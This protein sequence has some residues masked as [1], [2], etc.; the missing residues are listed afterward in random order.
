MKICKVA[1]CNNK[2]VIEG[3]CQRHY[4]HI[5]RYG[6]I[7]KRTIKDPNEIILCGNYAEVVIYNV[8]RNE[9]A[10][11]LIS[12]KDVE[13]TAKHKWCV[14]SGYATSCI[15]GKMCGMNRFIM[16]EELIKIKEK[17]DVDHINGNKLDN[18]RSNLRLATRSQNLM[19]KKH[20]LG[21]YFNKQCNK[22]TAQ[23]KANNK[24][25]NLGAYQNK[26]EALKVRRQ[27]EL[28]YFKE[29]AK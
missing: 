24:C 9:V 26:E 28:K 7:L 23:I 8:K 6:K 12:L 11:T 25:I 5:R 22:W 1:G 2:A 3:R 17:R 10:R 29:F 14:S 19:N 20:A 21:I 27:A 18:R 4:D 15:D 13:K 16:K